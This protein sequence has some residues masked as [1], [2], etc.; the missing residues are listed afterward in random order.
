[1]AATNST[2]LLG[3]PQWVGS[4]HMEWVEWNEGFQDIEKA[5]GSISYLMD[6]YDYTWTMSDN[7]S[8]NMEITVT[9]DEECPYSASMTAEFVEGEG[10][11]LTVTVKV[12]IEGETITGTHTIGDNGGNGGYTNG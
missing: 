6:T 12:T 9:V 5:I 4:D 3:L 2:K 7:G 8:G 10:R 1:M 11:A